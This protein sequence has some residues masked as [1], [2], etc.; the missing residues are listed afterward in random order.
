MILAKIIINS[1]AMEEDRK[2][3]DDYKVR[4]TEVRERLQLLYGKESPPVNSQNPSDN[5]VPVIIRLEGDEED[6]NKLI[7]F[8]RD[9]GIKFEQYE[10][11]FL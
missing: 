10:K 6:I 2:D 11:L 4:W 5:L 1:K 7:K 8:L 3:Y 9:N